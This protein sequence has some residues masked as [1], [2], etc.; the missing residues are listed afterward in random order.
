MPNIK[1]SYQIKSIS[2]DDVYLES[3]EILK[4]LGAS[5]IKENNTNMGIKELTGTISS[6]WGWGGMNISVHLE[7]SSDDVLFVLNGYIAQ[8]STSPLTKQMD[9]FLQQLQS[10]LKEKHNC[11]FE[12]EKLTRF[13]PK[14]KMSIN[15][16]DKKVF[17]TIAIV[18][19]VT[20]LLGEFG[21]R[22]VEILLTGIV[23][24]MGYKLGKKYLYK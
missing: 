23:V 10:T 7:Q 13:L 24:L 1:Q 16:K 9:N 11:L 14:Y 18:L 12:Y 15:I 4:K 17:I 5:D 19:F 21:G 3:L 8:M 6:V 20:M 2:I 22:G